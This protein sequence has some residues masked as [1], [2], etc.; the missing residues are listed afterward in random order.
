MEEVTVLNMCIF[1]FCSPR[2]TLFDTHLSTISGVDLVLCQRVCSFP[3]LASL[4]SGSLQAYHLPSAPKGALSDSLWVSL[5][6][7]GFLESLDDPGAQELAMADWQ[8]SAGC[9]GEPTVRGQNQPS[10]WCS[11]KWSPG[12][13]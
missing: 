9:D 6:F 4:S 7:V 11:E 12:A 13:T 3:A 5:L 10:K 2:P 1:C 8:L